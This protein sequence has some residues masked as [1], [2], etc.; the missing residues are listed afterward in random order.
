MLLF[1]VCFDL[2]SARPSDS[3][4]PLSAIMSTYM[5]SDLTSLCIN[6]C[7]IVNKMA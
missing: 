2:S 3:G 7:K 5:M 1:E 6:F 4:Q